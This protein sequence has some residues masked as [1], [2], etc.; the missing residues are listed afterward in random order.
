MKILLGN[1][2]LNYKHISIGRELSYLLN[3]DMV[4]KFY[5]CLQQELIQLLEHYQNKKH[6]QCGFIFESGL[7]DFDKNIAFLNIYDLE[8]F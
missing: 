8:N 7:N 1:K 6:L 2:E 4:I 5:S 3:V